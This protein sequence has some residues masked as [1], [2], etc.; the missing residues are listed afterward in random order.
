MKQT[1]VI[2][3]GGTIII[4]LLLLV[5]GGV[6]MGKDTDLKKLTPMQYHVTKECGTEPPFKNAY[7]NNHEPGI[8]VDVVSGEPLFSSTDKFESGTGWPSFTKPLDQ[9]SVVSKTDRTLGMIRTEVRSDKADSHLGHVFNDGPAPTGLR[10]CINSAALR[11][12]PVQN[13]EKEGYGQYKKMFNQSGKAA[14]IKP[15]HTQE[16]IFAAG[17]FW[18]VEHAFKQVRGVVKTTVGY[19]G[20]KTVNPTY[21]QVCSGT[22]GHA[23]AVRVTFDPNIIPFDRLLD[24]FWKMHDP[25]TLNRQGPDHGEQYRSAIFYKNSEQKQ[26]AE[27]SIKN[28]EASRELKNKVVTEITP[29]TDFYPAEEY[30]QDY[31]AKHPDKAACHV[32][33]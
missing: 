14:A 23:E 13:L 4:A 21:P 27:L 22:S 5:F 26:A 30:H 19:T 17:C 33:F 6:I 28:L 8:Y 3:K 24:F 7:W 16:A 32:V 1:S 20:G 18:G 10:Y 12:I 9:K 31:F 15:S 29:E 25:T 2:F 11:F